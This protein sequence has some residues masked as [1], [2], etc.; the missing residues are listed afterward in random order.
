LQVDDWQVEEAKLSS[1][2]SASLYLSF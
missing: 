2:P 1:L